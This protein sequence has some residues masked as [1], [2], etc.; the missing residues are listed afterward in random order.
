[1]I[2]QASLD[3]INLLLKQS[4]YAEAK[5][6]IGYH[7]TQHP[8]DSYAKYCYALVLLRSG[9]TNESRKLTEQL[10]TE[11]PDD[12]L[13]IDLSL[14]IDLEDGNL[15]RAESKALLLLE[16]RPD[17]AEHYFTLA[18]VKLSQRSYDKAL[19]AVNNGL[20]I[21]AENLSGLNLKI[22]L[23]GLLGNKSDTKSAI[24]NAL[25]LDAEDPS[26][27]A[28]QAS[29]M[30]RE[31]KVSQALDRLQYALSL[32]PTNQ[33]A[34]HY[35][36]EAIK[37]KF[38]PY[39]MFYKYKE[40]GARLSSA[41][42]W[43]LVIGAYLGY[44]VILGVARNNSTLEPYLMPLVYLIMSLFLLTWVMDPLMNIYLLTNKYGRV[45]LDRDE[46]KMAQACLGALVLA[47]IFLC[48][49]AVGHD[50]V[51]L[52]NAAVF[53]ACLIPLGTFLQP[54]RKKNRQIIFAYTAG[55]LLAAISVVIFRTSPALSLFAIGLFIYQF[56]INGILIKE[57][58]RIFE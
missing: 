35:M 41:G 9:D 38:W 32:D 17:D 29:Q 36:Q 57:N 3:R 24:E 25:E 13:I 53:A 15:D 37:S 14:Q 7:L 12:E 44:R 45:L 26:S 31:G 28:N 2:N 5:E 27:I 46:T 50:T 58:A 47:L 21:D 52:V 56:V 22:T 34:Q 30:L 55:L 43:K 18:R 1:M 39:R 11:N 40:L 23:D 49:Y 16:A 33:L 20:E 6:Y 42:S 4:R 19:E 8:E 48:I 10:L 51:Q 54:T